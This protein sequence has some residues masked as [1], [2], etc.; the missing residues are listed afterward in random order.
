MIK[1]FLFRKI[2]LLFFVKIWYNNKIVKVGVFMMVNINGINVNYIDEGSGPPVLLL[3]GWGSSSA[4]YR[5]IINTIKGKYRCIAP[6]F[7]GCGKSSTMAEP[8]TLADYTAFI[9]KFC[10]ALSLE[11]PIIF[12]HSHGG[13][14]ALKL[15]ADGIIEP[16]KMVLLDS[17]GLIPKKSLKQKAR[18]KSFKII[19][20]VL[21]VP[22]WKDSC[23]G[24]LSKARAHYGSADYN[25]APPVLRQTLVNL[26]NTDIRDC[27]P[28]I[29]ASTLLIWGDKDTATPL[30]D[31]KIIESLIPDCGLCVIE[32]TG[33]WSFV[34]NP[35]LAHAI[36]K[37]FLGV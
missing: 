37:N 12:G 3:H 27:L 19:K 34:E 21:T 33:H 17:A 11:N 15:A 13:R 20:S 18:A 23:E 32:N 8:W 35:G 30:V 5:G 16:K 28:A 6:D 7:P 1:Y 2:L 14:V 36:I 22:L 24:L 26:V 10:D 31:A 25:A 29:K 4:A 9:K